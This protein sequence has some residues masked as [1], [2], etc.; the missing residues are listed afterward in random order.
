MTFIVKR[1]TMAENDEKLPWDK[2]KV[3]DESKTGFI[4]RTKFLRFTKKQAIKPF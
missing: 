1:E 4:V 2:A 3:V